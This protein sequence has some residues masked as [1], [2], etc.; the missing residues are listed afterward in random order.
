[1]PC[2]ANM[3]ATQAASQRAEMADKWA[4]HPARAEP[5][6]A[7]G[8]GV[9]HMGPAGHVPLNAWGMRCWNQQKK[10][11]DHLVLVTT[12]QELRASWMVRP[13]E[14]RPEIA[15]DDEQRKSGGWQLQKR[16]TTR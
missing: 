2:T 1:M 3:L 10:R 6:M 8:R 4:G 7:W 9:E 14:E 11:T 16:S 5:R 12:A 15:P 13:Y